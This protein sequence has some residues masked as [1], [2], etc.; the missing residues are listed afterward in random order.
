M[1]SKN[2]EF[3]KKT[4][5]AIAILFALSYLHFLIYISVKAGAE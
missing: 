3:L 2:F 4:I 5:T 1:I